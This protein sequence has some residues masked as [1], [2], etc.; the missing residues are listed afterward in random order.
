MIN[1]Y[2][3]NKVNRYDFHNDFAHKIKL[4]IR[5]KISM[6][7]LNQHIKSSSSSLILSD[8]VI[9]TKDIVKGVLPHM[10]DYSRDYAKQI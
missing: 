8:V 2:K 7:I 4:F 9:N 6:Y 10:D 1:K 5:N 3:I